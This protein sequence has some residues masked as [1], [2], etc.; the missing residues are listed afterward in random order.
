VAIDGRGHHTPDPKAISQIKR[1]RRVYEQSA[2]IV[3]LQGSKREAVPKTRALSWSAMG[4]F[5]GGVGAEFVEAAANFCGEGCCGTWV[6]YATDDAHFWPLVPLRPLD[7]CA[8]LRPLVGGAGAVCVES[9]GRPILEKVVRLRIW[10]GEMDGQVRQGEKQGSK[11]RRGVCCAVRVWRG[12]VW[13]D[14][15][16][17][18]VVRPGLL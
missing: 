7:G 4:G 14:A 2:S 16:A 13:V 6:A 17:G 12:V 3:H 1:Q 18:K 11:V 5:A 10:V 9:E 15:E 8:L